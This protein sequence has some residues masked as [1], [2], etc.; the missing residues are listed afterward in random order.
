MM[1]FEETVSY[2]RHEK[3]DTKRHAECQPGI[4]HSGD[5]LIDNVFVLKLCDRMS[6]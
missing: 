3:Y 1:S 6:A 2:A 5:M 4:G